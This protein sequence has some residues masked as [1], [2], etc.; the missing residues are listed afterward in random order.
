MNRY[1]IL[2]GEFTVDEDH[3]ITRFDDVR[4]I[5]DYM[6]SYEGDWY[7]DPSEPSIPT[8][9]FYNEEGDQISIDHID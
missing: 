3:Q 8:F 9:G 5:I 7:P 2:R 4:T 1:E 6:V